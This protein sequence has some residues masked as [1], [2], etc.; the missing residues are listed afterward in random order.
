MTLRRT[1]AAL[2]VPALVLTGCSAS[3]EAPDPTAEPTSAEASATA[4]AVATPSPSADAG[5]S[6]DVPEGPAPEGL[7]A[8]VPGNNVDADRINLIVTGDGFESGDDFR[9]IAEQYIGWDG[10]AQLLDGDGRVTTDPDQAINADPGVFGIEPY[11]SHRDKF[12]VWIAEDVSLPEGLPTFNNVEAEQEPFDLPHQSIVLLK[13]G[14]P[15]FDSGLP[16]A[17]S[18]LD[19]AWV[20]VEVPQD[21]GEDPFSNL[22]VSLDPAYP[23]ADQRVLAHEL[24]HALFGLLDE[25]IG[26]D[27][28]EGN[29]GR[30]S[31]WPAC[32]QDKETAEA[33]WGDLV[34]E[35]DPAIEVYFDEMDAAGF[36]VESDRQD[37]MREMITVGYVD[38]GCYGSEG[39]FRPT[40]DSLMGY[41]FPA[42]GAVNRRH[43]ERILDLF[44]GGLP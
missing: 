42:M 24:G 40:V 12:N 29:E 44:T 18:G 33:W 9:A 4:E 37:I 15:D 32:A 11:K 41:N 36:P 7:E 39:S 1:A 26:Q 16:S 10:T 17:V 28:I 20:G 31:L 27:G 5:R 22:Y 30:P 14:K 34:G 6:G 8:L 19:N 35:V 38:S 3:S 25:Y 43:A 21:A 23:A 2:L 13:A